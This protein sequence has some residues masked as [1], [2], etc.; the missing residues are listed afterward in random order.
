MRCLA[1]RY[2]GLILFAD[3]Y[4]VNSVKPDFSPNSVR[5]R[6]SGE[7]GAGRLKA[8]IWTLILAG[9]IFTCVKVIPV[10]VNEYEL[11]DGMQTI[12]RFA[13]VNRQSPG[14]IQKAVLAEA[15]KDSVPLEADDI[16]V[17]AVNGNIRIHA[18]YSVTVDLLVYRWTLN[19][20]PEASNNALT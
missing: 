14:D 10:L 4:S 20:H 6:F 8:I 12:A 9:F 2:V 3:S 13:S 11:Q 15:Q 1:S 18:D 16:K 19:F 5:V 7:R 17:E